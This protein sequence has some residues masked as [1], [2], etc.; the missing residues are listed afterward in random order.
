MSPDVFR[1]NAS[2]SFC[3]MQ[4]LNINILFIKEEQLS[5]SPKCSFLCLN[6][7]RPA[8]VGTLTFRVNQTCPDIIG[9]IQSKFRQSRF[10]VRLVCLSFLYFFRFYVLQEFFI[11]AV[12]YFNILRILPCC[13]VLY[14]IAEY[15]PGDSHLAILLGGD[16]KRCLCQFSRK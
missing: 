11:G 1:E 9:T 6:L 16:G 8:P 4:Y 13:T 3:K 5:S 15:L 7:Y 12:L 10:R 2:F 14:L